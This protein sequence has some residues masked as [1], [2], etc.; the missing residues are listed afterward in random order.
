[1]IA[2]F[3]MQVKN[4]AVIFTL[5]KNGSVYSC[6]KQC[7]NTNLSFKHFLLL[8]NLKSFMS[9]RY[10]EESKHRREDGYLCILKYKK[11]TA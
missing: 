10:I 5:E 7:F 6:D 4:L 2:V 3:S 9:T 1:M 11:K 8:I